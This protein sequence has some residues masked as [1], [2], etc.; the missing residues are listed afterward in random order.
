[1]LIEVNTETCVQNNLTPSQFVFLA[2]LWQKETDVALEILSKD[3]SLKDSIKDLLDRGFLMMISNRYIIERKKCN[4][5]FGESE[6]SDFWEFFSTFPLK[7][8]SNGTSRPLR[9]QDPNSKNALEARAK[10]KAK[11]KSKAMHKHV[12]AC[13]NAELDNRKRSNKLGYMQNIITWLHQQT[14]QMSEYL[15]KSENPKYVAPKHGE[16]LV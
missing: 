1:M 14:W 16:G 12:M 7:V 10:Y 3:S 2:L 8:M 15:L 6:D 11:V 13:L 9:A 4:E 5:L